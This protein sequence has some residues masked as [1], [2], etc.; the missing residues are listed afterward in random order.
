MA[1]G[2]DIRLKRAT[3]LD[4]KTKESVCHRLFLV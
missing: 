1:D 3:Y 2:I 4:P